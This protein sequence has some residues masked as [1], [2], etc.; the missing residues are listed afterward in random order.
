MPLSIPSLVFLFPPGTFQVGENYFY[1]TILSINV[2]LVM[3]Q[4]NGYIG[5]MVAGISLMQCFDRRF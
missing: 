2:L 5:I 3:Q 1:W 4:L